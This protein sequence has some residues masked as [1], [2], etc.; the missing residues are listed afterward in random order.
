MGVYGCI[1]VFDWLSFV[2]WS[3]DRTP[4]WYVLVCFA[5]FDSF[6]QVS[7]FGCSYYELVEVLPLNE[8][9]P[10]APFDETFQDGVAS[11]HLKQFVA[12]LEVHCCTFHHAYQDSPFVVNPSLFQ[13]EH[14]GAQKVPSVGSCYTL[15]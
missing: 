9:C 7:S 14:H 3:P 10:L 5:F 15:Y 12:V 2:F 13:E 1:W 8:Y 11:C 4:F 6:F